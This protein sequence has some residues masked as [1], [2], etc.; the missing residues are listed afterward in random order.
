VAWVRTVA[1]NMATSRWRRSR[2]ALRHL[3]T[4]REQ[5]VQAP[6]PDRVAL[7]RALATL[8]ANHRRAI[9]LY[10][11]AGLSVGEVAAH[12]GVA[13]GTVRSWLHRA[14]AALAAQLTDSQ[15]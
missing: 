5:Q 6:N 10:H 4:Q 1:W 15:D 2:V 8:P 11:L 3:V 14:R 13:E 9:V 12:E 7:T